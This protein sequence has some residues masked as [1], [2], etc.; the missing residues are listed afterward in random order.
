MFTGMTKSLE[1]KQEKGSGMRRGAGRKRAG[2]ALLGAFLFSISFVLAG[3][4]AAQEPQRAPVNPDFLKYLDDL[5]SGRFVGVTPAAMGSDTVPS[6]VDLSHTAGR[7]SS[8]LPGLS[9]DL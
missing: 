8:L 1:K 7:E 2:I 3:G 4:L 5:N 9:A 6:L